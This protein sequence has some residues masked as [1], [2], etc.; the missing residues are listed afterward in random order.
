M[1]LNSLSQD[2]L[3]NYCRRTIENFEHWTRRL[4]HDTLQRQYGPNYIEYSKPNGEYLIKR[5]IRASVK[6]KMNKNP[7]RFTRPVDAMLL[8]EL[9]SILCNNQLFV[10]FREPLNDA[11]PEGFNEARTFLSRLIEPR[12]SL[13]HSNPISTRQA[14][15]IICYTNDVIDS[16][17]SFYLGGNKFMEYNAPQII[18]VTDSFGSQWFRESLS[19][20]GIG[21][22]IYLNRNSK[23]YLRPGDKYRIE[24]EVD[25]TFNRSDYR[26]EW[27]LNYG[28]M[29]GGDELFLA[30]TIDNSHVQETLKIVCMLKSMKEWHRYGTCDDSVAIALKVL[31]SVE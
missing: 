22:D 16:L 4:I 31:P 2:E 29:V 21:K 9:I 13:A 14:E 24:I 28:D 3:R 12:N 6:I 1:P 19:D 27:L 5:E 25:L 26:I 23:Y 30:L 20:S 11:F 17:K 18:K 8:N 7:S 15:Q 10:Y